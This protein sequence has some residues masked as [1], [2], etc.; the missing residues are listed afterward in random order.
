MKNRFVIGVALILAATTAQARIISWNC[1]DDGD[2]AIV[3]DAA[4]DGSWQVI[5]E[6]AGAIAEYRL[7]LRGDQFTY[8]AHV[9]GDFTTDTP[10][11]PIVWIVETVDNFTDFTWTDYHI[12]IGMNKTFSIVGVVAPPDWSS[13]IT[14][15]VGGQPLPNGG[16]GWLGS[17]DYYAG[18]PIPVGGSGQFGLVV[19]FAGSVEFCTEQIPTPEPASLIL[20]ALGS[21][22]LRR[23]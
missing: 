13:Q 18:T 10:E 16:T 4:T 8:P 17:V 6:S 15:P 22:L 5:D 20:L 12:D 14:Q 21:L 11:D 7:D 23:R 2:G 1:A 3:M 19:S 9:V